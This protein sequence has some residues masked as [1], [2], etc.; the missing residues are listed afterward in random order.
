MHNSRYQG[1]PLLRLLE[2]Y[3][4]KAVGRLSMSDSENLTA[5]EPKLVQLY[6]V[7]GT[8][9]QIVESVMKFPDTMPMLIRDVWKKNM[10]IATAN[11]AALDAQQFAEMF[12]DKN[13]VS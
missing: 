12:V 2:C 3:V 11:N 8:W 9:D 13:F 5:M 1:K 10:E 4:L 6:G 7:D